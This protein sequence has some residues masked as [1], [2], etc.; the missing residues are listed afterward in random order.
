MN[1]LKK[2]IT[3]FIILISS[4]AISQ[5]SCYTK[6]CL[7]DTYFK[8]EAHSGKNYTKIKV[9]EQPNGP[10]WEADTNNLARNSAATINGLQRGK[11]YL[12]SVS[13]RNRIWW[14]WSERCFY[15]EFTSSNLVVGG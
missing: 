10:S 12:I 9:I 7:D 2:C 8:V 13:G 5:D 6:T 11:R 15:N 4:Y 14:L 3:I 1:K